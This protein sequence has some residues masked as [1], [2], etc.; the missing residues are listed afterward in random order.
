[1]NLSAG[2]VAFLDANVLYPVLLRDVLLR[3]ASHG[4]FRARWSGRV[5]DEWMTALS[6]DRPDIP[7]ERLART[8]RLMD[9][10]FQDALVSGYEDRIGS[11]ALPDPNDRHVLAAAI[12]CGAKFIVTSNL[13]DFP[14]AT[15]LEHGVRAEHPDA[16]LLGR[17]EV[18]ENAVV[19]ALRRLRLSL[20]NPAMTPHELLTLM[21]N[22]R[23]G[24]SAN[25]QRCATPPTDCKSLHPLFRNPAEIPLIV[26]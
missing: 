10:H 7:F 14:E 22:R 18:D 11:L 12:H 25:A 9:E 15:L 19:A 8:R 4:V 1:M 2:V 17:V 21:E 20:H 24:A 23:L 16:F 3:L 6:R 5:H 26:N 13:R